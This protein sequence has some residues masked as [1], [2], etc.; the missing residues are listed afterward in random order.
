MPRAGFG[1]D[2][3]SA[4]KLAVTSQFGT[5]GTVGE[6]VTGSTGYLSSDTCFGDWRGS[7]SKFALLCQSQVNLQRTRSVETW[8]IC[9]LAPGVSGQNQLADD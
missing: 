3:E 4:F 8:G 7:A 5:F 2:G 1:V 9:C 6:T